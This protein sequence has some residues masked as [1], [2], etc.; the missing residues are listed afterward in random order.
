MMK[1]KKN[2]TLLNKFRKKENYLGFPKKLRKF[3]LEREI[4]P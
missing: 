2:F 3:E 1:G 4:F